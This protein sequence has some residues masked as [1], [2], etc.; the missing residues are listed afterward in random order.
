[1]STAY[2][3]VGHSVRPS[4]AEL[5]AIL[6]HA[7]AGN[8]VFISAMDIGQNLLDS[9]KLKV[10]E[11]YPDYYHDSLTV[12]I[13]SPVN[14]D[15]VKFTYPGARLDNYFTQ[16]DS[17][18]TNILGRSKAGY[19][20][21]VKFTYQGGGTVLIHLAPGALTNYFLLHKDN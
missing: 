1:N 10:S 2:I 17:S 3:I 9:F 8:H 21:F 14:G 7:I 12:S 11:D 13:F 16:M 5:K 19:A 15:S 20:N 6:S 18:V 4:E